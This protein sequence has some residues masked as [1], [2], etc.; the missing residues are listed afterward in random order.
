MILKYKPHKTIGEEGD[1]DED[2]IKILANAFRNYE[3]DLIEEEKLKQL[4]LDE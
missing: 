2:Q 1:N 4:E 3:S